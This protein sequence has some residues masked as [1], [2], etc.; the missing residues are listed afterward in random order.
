MLQ[1][2]QRIRQQVIQRPDCCPERL[3]GSHELQAH[4]PTVNSTIASRRVPP[5]PWNSAIQVVGTEIHVLCICEVGPGGWQSAREV[6][7]A[8]V[9]AAECLQ[10]APGLRN[11]ACSQYT[12][13]SIF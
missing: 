7:A 2:E 8:Q 3:T 11:A 10:G 6:V 1:I 4:K 5:D 12:G 13:H 9:N